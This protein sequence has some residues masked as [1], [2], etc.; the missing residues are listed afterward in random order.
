MPQH[1]DM[2]CSGSTNEVVTEGV[3]PQRRRSAATLRVDGCCG[4]RRRGGEAVRARHYF[5]EAAASLNS[6]SCAFDIGGLYAG[7]PVTVWPMT[8]LWMSCV[9]SYV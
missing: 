3:P 8:R 5:F 2:S 1:P 6:R 9:P 7:M 4:G